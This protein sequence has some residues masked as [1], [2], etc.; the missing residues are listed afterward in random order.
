MT[1]WAGL[2]KLPAGFPPLKKRG[3]IM[4]YRKITD[5]EKA[6]YV[7]DGLHEVDSDILEV[8]FR[9]MLLAQSGLE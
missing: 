8:L 1:R 2:G 9:I 4:E 7:T 3:N 5:E 6:K